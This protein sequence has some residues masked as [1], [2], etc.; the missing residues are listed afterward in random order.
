MNTQKVKKCVKECRFKIPQNNA[1]ICGE[2]DKF[3]QF[4]PK[5]LTFLALKQCIAMLT[6][7]KSLEW[8]ARLIRSL[9]WLI[10]LIWIDFIDIW[11]DWIDLVHLIGWLNEWINYIISVEMRCMP[12]ILYQMGCRFREILHQDQ[13]ISWLQ[14]S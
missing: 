12:N 2:N 6:R 3:W 1:E 14:I 7:P 4:Y 10:R 5:F 9:Y 13:H 11:V 8:C